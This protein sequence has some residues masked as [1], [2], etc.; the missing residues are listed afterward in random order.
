MGAVDEVLTPRLRIRMWEPEDL[1]ALAEI[2]AKPQV[3]H[4]PFGRGFS[5]EETENYLTAK[6]ADQKRGILSPSAA[7]DRATGGII[8]YISLA[9]PNYL[10]EIMPAVEIG[11][12]LDPSYWGRGLA[13]EGARALL[14]YGFDVMALSEIVSVYEPENVASGRVMDK[15]GMHLERETLHPAL[16]RPLR[17][18]RLSRKEWEAAKAG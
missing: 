14:E 16:D 17:V 2:F 9:P 3:W 12:R 5:E 7:E 10:P 4:F 8:G 6:I 11:W 18:H 15:L 1:A 13:T